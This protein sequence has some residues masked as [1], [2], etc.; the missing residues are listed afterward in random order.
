MF[1]SAKNIES[2]VVEW[3][4][5]FP[6]DKWF[7]EKYKLSFNSL[8]HR[9]ISQ[10]DIFFEYNEDKLFKKYNQ[11]NIIKKQEEEDYKN[12]ILLKDRED[13]NLEDAFDNISISQLQILSDKMNKSKE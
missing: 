7:R 3:N 9:S 2:L 1:F 12:G 8:G 11:D 5:R 13:K 6:L 10:I 4:N